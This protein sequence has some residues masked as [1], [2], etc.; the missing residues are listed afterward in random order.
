[1]PRNEEWS[2]RNREDMRMTAVKAVLR[3]DDQKGSRRTEGDGKARR[4]VASV[5]IF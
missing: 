5:A 3:T 2:L 1:M 4:D